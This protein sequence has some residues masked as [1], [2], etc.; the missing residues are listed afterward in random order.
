MHEY[1]SYSQYFDCGP[2]RR[3]VDRNSLCGIAE[4]TLSRLL[5]NPPGEHS[6]PQL[7]EMLL[8]LSGSG[9]YGMCYDL[10][11]GWRHDRFQ[12]GDLLLAPPNF[13][14]Q[15]H[16]DTPTNFQ[17]IALPVNFVH[18]CLHELGCE[19]SCDLGV[20]H[21]QKFRDEAIERHVLAM[22]AAANSP[23]RGN[24]I[25]IDQGV[26][27]LIEQLIDKAGYPRK[28]PREMRLDK[29][30][31]RQIYEYIESNL[32]YEITLGD[33]AS[34]AGFSIAHFARAFKLTVGKS[35]YAY[36]LTARIQRAKDILRATEKPIA[37]IALD[38]GF[39]SQAH[40]TSLFARFVGTTPGRFR[41]DE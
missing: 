22:F 36:V 13:R 41:K 6:S 9:S 23:D 37:D 19:E 27:M 30:I 32:Q 24:T 28:R 40:L 3:Y 5:R 33:L 16:T 4:I 1:R 39:S 21:D 14:N 12:P 2:Q 25:L 7:P 17:T 35:P 38:C 18:E 26:V 29:A 8:I 15:Y 11:M 34:I 10:G 31:V 20:L